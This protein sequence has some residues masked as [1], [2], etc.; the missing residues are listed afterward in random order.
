MSTNPSPAPRRNPQV[1]RLDSLTKPQFRPG[2]SSRPTRPSQPPSRRPPPPRQCPNADCT[3]K[4]VGEEDGQ[5]LCRG[6]GTVLNESNIVSEVQ[7]QEAANGAHLLMGSHVGADQAYARSGLPGPRGAMTLDSREITERNGRHWLNQIGQALHISPSLIDAGMQ[8]FKLAAANNFIQGRVTKSVTAVCLYIACRMQPHSNRMMLL[9]FAD[10]LNLNVFKLGHIYKDLIE[11]LRLQGTG[12][13]HPINPEDLVLRFAERLE[14]ASEKMKV[15]NDAVRI[16]QRFN[17]DWMSPGR[18]PAGVVGAAL[19]L[20]ARM[21]NFH[22]TTREVGHVAK[23]TKQ[24]LEIRLDEFRKT[25]SSKLTVDEF[26]TIDLERGED[27]PAFRRAKEEAEGKGKEKKR[28]R[29]RRGST[30]MYDDDGGEDI[31]VRNVEANIDP[32]LQTPPP[33]QQPVTSATEDQTD[34][35]RMPPPPLPTNDST[36]ASTTTAETNKPKRN[37]PQSLQPT[38]PSSSSLPFNPSPDDDPALLAATTD[39]TTLAHASALTLTLSTSTSPPQSP[40][41][42]S[43]PSPPPTLPPHPPP[44]SSPTLSASEFASDPEVSSCLLTPSETT[45]KTRIWTHENRDWLREQAAK[46]HKRKLDEESGVVKEVKKRRKRRRRRMG[47]LRDYYGKKK[48]GGEKRGEGSQGEGE[49]QGDQDEEEEEE[50]WTGSGVAATAGEAIEKML[51]R[52]GYSKKI[53]YDILKSFDT[54]KTSSNSTLAGSSSTPNTSTIGTPS[55]STSRQ[56]SVSLGTPRN[57]RLDSVALD[58]GDENENENDA[59]TAPVPAAGMP[60]A[61]MLGKIT[62]GN[63][64]I[65]NADGGFITDTDKDDG[66]NGEVERYGEMEIEERGG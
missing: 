22:R 41:H 56:G 66:N 5:L 17:R 53:N 16:V 60:T 13:I 46:A 58:Q 19:I 65:S 52:R 10:V 37:E 28:R 7:F 64:N 9:D 38:P 45:L 32:Q 2:H 49:A 50:E 8:L 29:I 47:D 30:G 51:R 18:R 24:T 27:P 23:I 55:S 1:R 3:N 34:K 15:A 4:D 43:S 57:E 14:F 42:P 59:A 20:A 54:R 33:T 31:P 62:S 39:P 6:C 21:N 36:P 63:N 25:E 26:R 35:E 11:A 61:D 48:K 12:R 44:R 40:S